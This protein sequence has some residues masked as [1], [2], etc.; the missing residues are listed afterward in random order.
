MAQAIMSVVIARPV[1]D[2]F[3]VLTDP[4]LAP[5]WAANAI[6]GELL[7]GGPVGVGSRRRAVVKGVFGRTMESVMEVTAFERDRALELRLVSASWGGSGRTRYTLTPEGAATRIEWLWEMRPGGFLK[8]FDRP[9]MAMFQR[10]FQ[11]DLENLR[12]MMESH[13]L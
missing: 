4:T 12:A 5:R 6:K 7:T 13:E 8:P 2:V 3:R 9:F 10:L 1:A 11:R